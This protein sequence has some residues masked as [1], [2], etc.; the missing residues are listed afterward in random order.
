MPA[1]AFVLCYC[2]RMQTDLN[3]IVALAAIVGAPVIAVEPC[4]WGFENRT[5]IVTLDGG[6]RLVVQR[7]AGRAIARHKLRLARNLPARLAAAGLRAPRLLA[8]NASARPP[9][10]VREYLPGEPG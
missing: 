8:E 6:R 3:D 1:W 7:I 5:V 4:G 10:A 9:Y 2:N